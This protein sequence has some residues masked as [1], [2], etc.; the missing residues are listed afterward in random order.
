MSCENTVF[1]VYMSHPSDDFGVAIGQKKFQVDK[2]KK[3]A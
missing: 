3:H 1:P 2:K